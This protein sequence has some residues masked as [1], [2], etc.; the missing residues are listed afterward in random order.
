MPYRGRC[1]F[2]CSSSALA[3]TLARCPAPPCRAPGLGGER[4][5]RSGLVALALQ[6]GADCPAP[7][8][9]WPAGLSPPLPDLIGAPGRAPRSRLCLS[10]GR[11]F[12]R[13]AG[14]PGLGKAD[15]DRLLRGARAVLSLADV[16]DLLADEL[17]CR[18]RG[19]LAFAQVLLRPLHRFL[20]GHGPN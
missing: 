15:G 18:G 20:L 2:A 10:L 6:R 19:L 14:P 17:A 9:G 3:W 13:H 5:A 8:R 1:A 11:R 12:E 4:L 7:P 16:L